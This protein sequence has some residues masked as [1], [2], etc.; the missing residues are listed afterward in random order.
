EAEREAVEKKKSTEHSDV[1]SNKPVSDVHQD[2]HELTK[3]T[4]E[5]LNDSLS[6]WHNFEK[7]GQAFSPSS[8]SGVSLNEAGSQEK[9]ES[10]EFSKPQHE[11]PG[12]R[13]STTPADVITPGEEIADDLDLISGLICEAEKNLKAAIASL[14]KGV[15]YPEIV[16]PEE[17]PA[18]KRAHG[19]DGR[20]DRIG[21]D[22]FPPGEGEKYGDS[23][24][25]VSDREGRR[26]DRGYTE[27]DTHASRAY[28]SSEKGKTTTKEKAFSEN[29]IKALQ[30]LHAQ[31]E[32]HYD[33][34]ANQRSGNRVLAKEGQLD[35]DADNQKR[36]LND[37]QQQHG[38]ILSAVTGHLRNFGNELTNS[39]TGLL[40][41]KKALNL[42]FTAASASSPDAM[43][44]FSNSFKLL[45]AQFGQFLQ[46]ALLKVSKWLQDT[47]QNDQLEDKF[48]S[49]KVVKSLQEL[50]Q[51][52]L[53]Q[54]TQSEGSDVYKSQKKFLD[55]AAHQNQDK[56]PTIIKYVQQQAE[57][58]ASKHEWAKNKVEELSSLVE[59]A[60]VFQ[61]QVEKSKGIFHW[62][63]PLPG[64]VDIANK[65]VTNEDREKLAE[66]KELLLKFEGQ[67][68]AFQDF[69]DGLNKKFDIPQLVLPNFR[70]GIKES[71]G[72]QIEKNPYQ[73]GLLHSY[74]SHT[75]PA[76]MGVEEMYKNVQL[77]ALQNDPLQMEIKNIQLKQLEAMCKGNLYLEKLAKDAGI[78]F[79]TPPAKVVG[80]GR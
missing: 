73:L 48:H 59:T 28:E 30:Q 36:K 45:M 67:L 19:F 54:A 49:P 69:A 55:I 38:F 6:S 50:G 76:F 68:L 62:L 37:G 9:S 23:S 61:N 78:E 10:S 21:A 17:Q 15:E 57:F 40:S 53:L 22:F 43:A 33:D 29:E 60:D 47:V 26:T 74:A 32:Q 66:A 25:S 5:K 1:F 71:A 18:V 39:I 65:T 24:K 14:P 80:G 75:Q 8:A 16:R 31:A 56:L 20:D 42:A 7:E 34:R 64:G 3:T 79:T 2:V 41:F 70:K 72:E 77:K 35:R 46:P 12:G 44:T 52:R 27:S 51:V 63:N 4:Q 58:T 11:T 13:S